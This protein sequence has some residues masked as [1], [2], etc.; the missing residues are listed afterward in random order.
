MINAHIRRDF[1]SVYY[2]ILVKTFF[3]VHPLVLSTG[4]VAGSD[5]SRA[6]GV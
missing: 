6:C 4:S 3:N 1:E 2:L 5:N